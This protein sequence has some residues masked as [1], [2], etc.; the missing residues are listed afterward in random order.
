MWDATTG[1]ELYTL[2]G[3]TGPVYDLAFS[4]DGKNLVTAGRDGT[5]RVYI[6]PLEEVIALARSRLTRTWTVEECQRFLHHE[7]CPAWP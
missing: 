6:L 3:H 2:T 5:V 7:V 4:P 1:Q